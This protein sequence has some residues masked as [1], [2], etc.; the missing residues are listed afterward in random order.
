MSGAAIG[1]GQQTAMED[2]VLQ[3]LSQRKMRTSTL[4][5]EA[6]QRGLSSADVREVVWTLLD[7]GRLAL[8][9]DRYLTCC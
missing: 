8:T 4:M 9:P 7:E 2:V 1:K 6:Q 5:E 3:M